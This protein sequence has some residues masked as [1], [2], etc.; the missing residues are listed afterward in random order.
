M[1]AAGANP[2]ERAGCELL[3]RSNQLP[4]AERREHAKKRSGVLLLLGD[5]AAWDA[6]AIAFAIGLEGWLINGPHQRGDA[7][8]LGIRGG[9]DLLRLAGDLDEAADS[10]SILCRPARIKDVTEHGRSTL[11]A[12]LR[13]N[14]FN[15]GDT[16]KALG[17][18]AGTNVPV[19]QRGIHFA[20]SGLLG[21][22]H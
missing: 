14:V 3:F 2:I 19:V 16:A 22:Q 11:G 9:E 7:V 10:V 1:S 6:F 12:E 17:F 15:A 20:L 8:P 5:R 13:Q 4:A 18:Q 21:E